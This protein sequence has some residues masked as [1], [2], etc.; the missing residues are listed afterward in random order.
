MDV[1]DVR[2]TRERAAESRGVD[3]EHRARL[4]RGAPLADGRRGTMALLPARDAAPTRRGRCS[5]ESRSR[6]PVMK[7]A[8]LLTEAQSASPGE[9]IEWRDRIPADVDRGIEAVSRWLAYNVLAWFAIRVIDRAGLDGH[10]EAA[11]QALRA[12]R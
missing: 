5:V 7:L 3:P 12:W 11:T 2:T 6:E 1:V 10:A 8:H 4:P 9:R